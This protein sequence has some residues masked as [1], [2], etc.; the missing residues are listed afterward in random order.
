MLLREMIDYIIAQLSAADID[1][2]EARMIAR[3]L[4][5]KRLDVDLPA[6]ALQHTLD[7]TPDD[8][9]DDLAHLKKGEPLQYLLGETEFMGLSFLSTPSALIPRGDSE[10]VAEY[11]IKLME[12]Q[13]QPKIADICC[14]CGTYAL[15][16]A[17]FLPK[18]QVWATD[19]SAD[20]LRLAKSNAQRLAVSGQVVFL[21]G[22]LLIPLQE[23]NILFDL[24]IS[25]PPYIPSSKLE[26]LPA[27]VQHEPAL[28]LDG[29]ADGLYFY[30][31]LAADAKDLLTDDGLVLLEHGADQAD[32]I[33]RIMV[34]AGF[35]CQDS[36][37]DYGHNPRGLLFMLA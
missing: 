8:I 2:D 4:L 16:L 22:D 31:R 18:A 19:I 15:A 25:N 21:Q 34:D 13:D 37:R 32:A 6:L 7:L 23:K 5:A 10:V 3:L 33:Q 35:I 20:A 26:K 17:A 30:R 27:Q 11:G 9:A 29:G 12:K 1:Q 36:I 24:I 14:G 28:A